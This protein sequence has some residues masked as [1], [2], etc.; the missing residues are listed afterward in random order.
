[1][2]I[3]KKVGVQFIA[4]CKKLIVERENYS[5]RILGM[6]RRDRLTDSENSMSIQCYCNVFF[7]ALTP[8]KPH[9][10]TQPRC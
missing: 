6:F 5:R 10:R 9:F 8:S 1:M 4:R 3:D 2:E 7:S